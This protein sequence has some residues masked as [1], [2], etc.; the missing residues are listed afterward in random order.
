MHNDD[1]KLHMID[2]RSEADYNL[3]HIKGAER[4]ALE[5]LEAR[6]GDLLL[7]PSNAVFVVISNNED[8][9]T[10][11]WKILQAEELHNVYLLEGGMNYW[12][13]VFVNKDADPQDFKLRTGDER[14]DFTFDAALGDRHPAATPDPEEF[15]LEYTPK[16]KLELKKGPTGGGCG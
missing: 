16:V 14:L 3:F 9:A 6:A 11:G 4:I 1:I 2:V 5:D 13:Q 12:L 8:T 10:E 7:E 15:E